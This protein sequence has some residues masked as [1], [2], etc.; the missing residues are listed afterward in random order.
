MEVALARASE[1]LPSDHDTY[2]SRKVIA[3]AIIEH[4]RTGKRPLESSQKLGSKP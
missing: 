2:E 1:K 3:N 4:A